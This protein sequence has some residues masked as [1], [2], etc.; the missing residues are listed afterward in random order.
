M[1]F[2]IR[3]NTYVSDIYK[4]QNYTSIIWKPLTKLQNYLTF[5]QTTNIGAD[6]QT[7]SD[8]MNNSGFA[9]FLQPSN[10]LLAGLSNHKHDNSNL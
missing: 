10:I 2:Y 1:Q 4:I 3:S 5:D 7:I 6:Q 8:F 9:R